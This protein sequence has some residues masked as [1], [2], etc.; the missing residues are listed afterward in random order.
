MYRGLLV[1][2]SRNAERSASSEIH[3]VLTE[4][5]GVE[6]NLFS[7]HETRISGL[8]T[9]SINPSVDTHALIRKFQELESE[10]AFFMHCL[11]IRPIDHLATV[12]TLVE[13]IKK[14]SIER[15]GSFRVSVTKRHNPVRSMD[16]I[17]A[18]ATLFSNP[19]SLESPDWEIIIEIVADKLGYSIIEPSLLF[20][21]QL[22]FAQENDESPNW[23]L[24]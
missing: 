19:V 18:V 6:E 11:K 22:A 7:V 13:S 3:Y 5:C 9:V 16:L 17:K 12:D 10:D 21:T 2:T 20:S 14:L 8:V 24:D 1:S 4:H 15:E 23:F